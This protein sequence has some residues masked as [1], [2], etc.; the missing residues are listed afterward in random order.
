M[1]YIQPPLEA[2]HRAYEIYTDKAHPE[3][4]AA[5]SAFDF[6][7]KGLSWL[8]PADSPADIKSKRQLFEDTWDKVVNSIARDVFPPAYIQELGATG[9][10]SESFLN[11]L[12]RCR[13]ERT[14]ELSFNGNDN[15]VVIRM[16]AIDFILIEA[17]L[18][19]GV[20]IFL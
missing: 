4:M 3:R 19:A 13:F 10:F 12:Q 5:T 14:F 8:S 1:S 18:R 6:T 9:A 11:H 20:A 16:R 2:I 15:R 17:R 7:L